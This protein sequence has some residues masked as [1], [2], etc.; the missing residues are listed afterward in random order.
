MIHL[1]E[2]WGERKFCG[3][4][5]IEDRIGKEKNPDWLISLLHD[6]ALL[7]YRLFSFSDLCTSVAVETT[8]PSVVTLPFF[9]VVWLPS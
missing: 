5:L 6:F 1:A 3:L 2:L 8:R 7:S 9:F 4:Y